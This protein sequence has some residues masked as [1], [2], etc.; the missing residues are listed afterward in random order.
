M[1]VA[2]V[3]SSL[4]RSA[5]GLYYSVSGLAGEVARQGV[6]LAVFGGADRHFA[7]DRRQWGEL[8]LEPYPQSDV[9]S[10]NWR[11]FRRL[12]AH[13]PD[14]LHLHGIWT[15]T[16]LYGRVAQLTGIPVVTSPHGMLER[17]ILARR[18]VA[19]AVHGALFE[20][21]LVRGGHVHALCTAEFEAIGRYAPQTTERMFVLPNGTSI[22]PTGRA[23]RERSGVLYLGRLHPKKQVLELAR[24]WA[25]SARLAPHMLTIAGWGDA[26][27][28]AAIRAVAEASVNI[29]FVG[30]LYGDEKARAFEAAQAFVLPSLS[31]GL[32]M[33]VLEALQH[34]CLPVITDQCNL[35]E[36]FADGAARR[37]TADFS[38]LER[39]VSAALAEGEPQGQAT[40]LRAYARRYRWSEI[41]GAMI[42]RYREILDRHRSG[43]R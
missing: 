36:L 2:Y 41:A 27:Y 35:P 25:R 43:Q 33:S 17:W 26:G 28:E 15:A 42:E 9:Y 12:L 13:K 29:R 14:L 21:P 39:V 37:I 18:K 31:E 4:T 23:H 30:A 10:F 40:F 22:V 32:P 8:P 16:S 20:R 6:E 24:A 19:K 3:S 11:V 5:G 34:G 1:R 38:D 7:E